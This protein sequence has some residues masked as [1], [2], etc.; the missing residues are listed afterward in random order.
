[1]PYYV[2]G[3]KLRTLRH[4]DGLSRRD[5]A[6]EAGVT[7]N[8][9]SN[10]ESGWPVRRSTV[11]KIARVL[12]VEPREVRCYEDYRRRPIPPAW[13]FIGVRQSLLGDNN[14]HATP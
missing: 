14:R 11:R 9:V 7:T 3:G 2:G 6:E 5:L 13:H 8:T 10:A 4:R 1:M 12:F